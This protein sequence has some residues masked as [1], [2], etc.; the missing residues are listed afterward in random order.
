MLFVVRKAK[1]Q[2][3]Q[4]RVQASG[5]AQAFVSGINMKNKGPLLVPGSTCGGEFCA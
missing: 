2:N 5:E 4:G 1:F 3:G